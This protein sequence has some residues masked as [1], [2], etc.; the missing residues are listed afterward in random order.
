MEQPVLHLENADI[1]QRDNLVLSKVNL[2]I[3][4]EL[5]TI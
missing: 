3:Q 2:S 4:K 5:F 1:Y